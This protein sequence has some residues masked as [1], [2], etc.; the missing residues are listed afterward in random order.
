MNTT[1]STD[2][3]FCKIVAGDVPS[4]QVHADENAIAFLDISPFKRGHT[5]VVPRRHVDDFVTD[6]TSLSEVAPAIEK[7]T[8]LL[9]ERLGCDGMNL[10]SSSGSVAGQEIFHLHVHLIPR[11]SAQPGLRALFDKDPA[12]GD[13]LDALHRELT[14]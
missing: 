9:T 2:C 6:P 5:L 10:F 3:L 12:A 1:E 11:Y 7:T 8:A 14:A 13:D 4:R